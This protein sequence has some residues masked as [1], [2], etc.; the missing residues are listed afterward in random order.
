MVAR[1]YGADGNPLGQEMIVNTMIEGGQENP[2]VAMA[3]NGDFIVAWDSPKVDIFG[4]ILE[5]EDIYARRFDTSNSPIVG[6]LGNDKLN[7]ISEADRREDLR[8]RDAL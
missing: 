7:G 5:P 4:R 6:T 2:A 1:Q 3:G 8:V